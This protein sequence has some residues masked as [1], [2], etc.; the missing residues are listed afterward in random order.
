MKPTIY[1]QDFDEVIGRFEF[2]ATLEHDHAGNIIAI[3]EETIDRDRINRR[4]GG[5]DVVRVIVERGCRIVID[6]SHDQYDEAVALLSNAGNP[7]LQEA[8]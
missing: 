6:E 4:H 7:Q 5:Y 8:A 2:E 3:A 1:I